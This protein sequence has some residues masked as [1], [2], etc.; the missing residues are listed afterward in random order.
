MRTGAHDY[1]LRGG[2]IS[3]DDHL[4]MCYPSAHRDEEVVADPSAPKIDRSPNR[5]SA[6]ARIRE[7]EVRSER[8]RLLTYPSIM[9]PSQ[10]KI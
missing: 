7:L 6:F 9:S 5:R 8:S 2:A 4:M 1:G 10:G 3:K